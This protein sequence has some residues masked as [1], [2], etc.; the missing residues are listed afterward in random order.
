MLLNRMQWLIE[1]LMGLSRLEAGAVTFRSI[2]INCREL[3]AA[4][5]LPRRDTASG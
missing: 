1:T 2:T 4:A 5:A 3:I